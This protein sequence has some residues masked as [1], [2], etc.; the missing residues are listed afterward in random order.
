MVFA[1]HRR[2]KK[3]WRQKCKEWKRGLDRKILHTFSPSHICFLI[4][5]RSG[6]GC[7]IIG[8]RKPDKLSLWSALTFKVY[9]AR[10]STVF[11]LSLT[12]TLLWPS[13][14]PLWSEGRMALQR[15]K[16]FLGGVH[17][18][19]LGTWSDF[20]TGDWG[21]HCITL[22]IWTQYWSSHPTHGKK[23]KKSIF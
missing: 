5:A 6:H 12:T 4:A 20:D 23:A 11:I 18:G 7:W 22:Q 21:L 8:F 2:H 16:G 3:W 1:P 9:Q 10:L 17:V 14:P 19:W 13:A 15:H